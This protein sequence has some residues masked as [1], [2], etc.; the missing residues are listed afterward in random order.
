LATKHHQMQRFIRYYKDETGK[1][2]V[3]MKEVAKFAVANGWELPQPSNP[4]DRLAKEFS[5]AAREETRYD[6]KTGRPYRAN[7]AVPLPKGGEQLR[8]WIDIDEA[9]RKPMRKSL[10][11]RRE[12]MVGDGLQLTLDADHWNNIHPE[13]DPINIPMDFTDDIEERKHAPGDKKRQSTVNRSSS[14]IS[15]TQLT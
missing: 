5:Q 15:P 1:T 12:Q 4:L 7:H 13:E 9:P 2:E 6:K 10:I 14:S 11:M 8:I 3:D